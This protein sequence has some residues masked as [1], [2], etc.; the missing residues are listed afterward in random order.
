MN[1]KIIEIGGDLVEEEKQYSKYFWKIDLKGFTSEPEKNK[2]QKDEDR[3]K[4]GQSQEAELKQLS[5]LSYILDSIRSKDNTF[6]LTYEEIANYTGVSKDTV[7]RIINLLGAN[8]FI[9]RK[10]K[11]TYM[12]N[13]RR[14]VWGRDDKRDKLAEIYE[15]AKKFGKIRESCKN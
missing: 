3:T 8:D 7:D 10:H 15:E 9:R 14:M 12:V 1:V 6:S 2:K 13:P 5:V 11:G 4:S